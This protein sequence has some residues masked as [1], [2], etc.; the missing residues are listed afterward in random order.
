MLLLNSGGSPDFLLRAES[1][2]AEFVE[3]HTSELKDGVMSM[4]PVESIEIPVGG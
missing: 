4:H 3:I 1:D 2:A